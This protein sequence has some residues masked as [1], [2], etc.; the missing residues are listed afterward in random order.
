VAAGQEDTEVLRLAASV[1]RGSEHPLAEAIVTAARERGLNL[2]EPRGME[3]IPG[4]GVRATVNGSTFLFGNPRLMEEAKVTLNGL[5]P[6]VDR[7]ALEGRTAMVLARDGAALGVIAVA[8]T[9]KPDS[10]EAV[11][12]LHRLGVEVAMMTGDNRRTAEA[13]ARQVGIDRVFAE[14]L[15]QDKAA[16]IK[17]LQAE[18]KRVGMVGDGIN[19]APALAQADVGIAIGTG[20]DIALESADVVLMRG[21][22]LGVARAIALSRQTLSTIRQN[23]FWAFFYN[24]ILIPLAAGVLYPVFR[25]GGVPEVLRPLLG[26]YGFLN[27]MLAALAMAFSSVSVVTNSLRLKRFKVT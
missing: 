6:Q 27:P 8:D 4:K 21:N 9:L 20:T 13:I 1:E 17:Q 25:E 12:A 24:T 18:G 15:P 23:L 10:A 3:A 14:V 2:E 7:L 22:V 11:R 19:D 16:Y 5:G 26:E